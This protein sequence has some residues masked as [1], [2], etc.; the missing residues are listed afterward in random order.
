MQNQ[1]INP[2][3]IESLSSQALRALQNGKEAE[4]LKLW[5]RLLQIMP[6]H[7]PTLSAMGQHAL[8]KGELSA[9]LNA[10]QR[11]VQI[12]GSDPQQW[13]SLAVC[14]RQ[15]G[16]ADAEDAAIQ[17]ALNINPRDLLALIMRADLYQLQ[18]KEYMAAM[19]YGAVAQVAPPP[20]QLHP[21]LHGSVLHAL[22]YKQEYDARH[23][24]F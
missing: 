19:A 20:A 11:V 2:Q 7:I 24:E 23:G 13:V 17:N 3:E 9:A 8:S 22:K 18:G 4:A 12:D 1:Q 6:N 21:S 10:Y 5:G 15:T 16:D 14:L